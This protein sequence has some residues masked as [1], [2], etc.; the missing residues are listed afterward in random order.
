MT[1]LVILT[2]VDIVLLVAG[3]A[4]YLWCRLAADQDRGQSGGVR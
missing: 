3:L 1:T 4:V 2:V